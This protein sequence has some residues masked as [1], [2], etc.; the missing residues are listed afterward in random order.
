MRI[1]KTSPGLHHWTGRPFDILI[2][3][4]GITGAGIARDA[5]LRNFRVAL[6]EQGDFGSGT[7]SRTSKLIHGGLRYLEQGRLSLVLKSSRERQILERMAPHLVRP[8][9]FLLPIYRG[10]RW[11][12]GMIR[13]GMT[14]YDLLAGS[15]QRRP[16]RMLSREETLRSEPGLRSE[17]LLGSALYYDHLMDDTRLCLVNLL[18]TQARGG[19]IRNHTQV[20]RLLRGDGGRVT[21]V[22]VRD[23]IHGEETAFYGRT[24]INAT[25]PWAD[26]LCQMENPG[27]PPKLRRTRGSH[28]ILPALTRNHA[29]IV[30]TQ[31]RQRVFFII[32]WQGYSLVGTTE[33]DFQGDPAEVQCPQEEVQELLQYAQQYFPH[34]TL[35]PGSVIATFS[36]V[37][38]LAHDPAGHPSLVSRE[39]AVDYSST[40][41]ITITGGKFTTYR[42]VAEKVVDQIQNRISKKATRPC[43]TR[44]RPL[45]GGEIS[46]LEEFVQEQIQALCGHPLIEASQIRHLVGH[47]GTRFTEVL[48]LLEED[49]VL[50]ERLLP[51]L[52]HIRAELLYAIRQECA[53]TLSDVLRRRMTVALGPHRTHAVLL[54]NILPIMAA[55]LGWSALEA[56]AQR[57][58]YLEE[59][60]G[61]HASAA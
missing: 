39:T 22:V 51:D 52:P 27:Q 7:S 35:Q 38:P 32:P 24:V 50:G 44:Q 37:R 12:R 53:R 23:R 10:E 1:P 9:P 18:E 43:S 60:L 29:L 11:S 41:L 45:W 16:H 25:G 26:D 49:P 3:G 4:G 20:T 8:L 31:D 58:A 57:R 28:I 47:Y 59:I 5:V 34:R 33:H 55:E 17:G 21:G 40:G 14:L 2:I 15:R 46:D 30:R 36:G 42:H 19:L 6:F 56:Q 54:K 61:S 48:E 13:V